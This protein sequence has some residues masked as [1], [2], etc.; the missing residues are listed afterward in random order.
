MGPVTGLICSACSEASTA[1]EPVAPTDAAPVEPA[2]ARRGRSGHE[3]RPAGGHVRPGDLL[4]NDDDAGLIHDPHVHLVDL[5]PGGG[6]HSQPS[7]DV[8]LQ[9]AL[10]IVSRGPASTWAGIASR[11]SFQSR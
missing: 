4:H 7:D 8:G 5:Q 2:R 6:Q 1:R 9:G 10:R 11:N 3:Q